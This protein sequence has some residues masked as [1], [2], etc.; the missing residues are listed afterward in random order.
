MKLKRWIIET[1]LGYFNIDITRPFP[2]QSTKI[3]K[4][5]FKDKPIVCA[6]VGV[7]YG[8]NARSILNELN[9]KKMYLIDPYK[10][11]KE[12]YNS[13]LGEVGKTQEQM[14][15]A[16]KKC[17]KYLWFYEDKIV[18]VN[19][20]SVDAIKDIKEGLDYIYIDA[21]HSYE[22][23]LDD[24]INYFSLLN[25]DGIIAGHDFNILDVALAVLRFCEDNN[26]KVQTSEMD[27]II[28]K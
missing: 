10:E 19:K 2:K 9:V 28:K 24:L 3:A 21:N 15:K 6:E 1:L 17:E 7:L 20:N 5:H 18:W 25:K 12:N 23:V 13:T 27:W 16:K 26:L 22:K 4:E 11:Y 8:H 14:D